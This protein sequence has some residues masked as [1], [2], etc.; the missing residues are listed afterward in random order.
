MDTN[1]LNALLENMLY[2]F[3]HP[4]I[5]ANQTSRPYL[6]SVRSASRRRFCMNV[7]I[8]SAVI[9]YDMAVFC[10]KIATCFTVFAFF[11]YLK[12]YLK[13]FKP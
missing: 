12:V 11:V 2:N 6:L 8:L 10:C 4:S 13:V 9:C 7:N 1:D 3:F 5:A